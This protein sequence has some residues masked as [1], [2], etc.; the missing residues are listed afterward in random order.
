MGMFD[1]WSWT[2]PEDLT[3]KHLALLQG[4]AQ[5]MANSHK[6][7]GPAFGAGV[8]AG[9][10]EYRYGIQQAEE[11]R[12]NKKLE[13]LRQRQLDL[14]AGSLANTASFQQR[15]LDQREELAKS[16]RLHEIAMQRTRIGAQKSM[17][18]RQFDYDEVAAYDQHLRN[19]RLQAADDRL[20]MHQA[21]LT[22]TRDQQLQMQM[23]FLRD[24]MKEGEDTAK[25]NE[26]LSKRGDGKSM[27]DMV[28]GLPEPETREPTDFFSN[29]SPAEKKA[30]EEQRGISRRKVTENTLRT[31]TS[32]K[33]IDMAVRN[34]QLGIPIGV[35]LTSD[36]MAEIQRILEGQ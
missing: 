1:N 30:L 16:Q 21:N 25:T 31:Q 26:Q 32:K 5:M 35:D 2:K 6:G 34:I 12:R 8:N 19:L 24:A 28:F 20:K 15:S 13:E 11:L 23:S 14:Q 27:F 9:L 17:Q 4:G 7:F 3:P 10:D 29:L 33:R 18:K 36:E 22:D